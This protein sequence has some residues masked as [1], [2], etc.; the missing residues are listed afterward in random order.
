MWEILYSC[1]N[2][3]G[4]VRR[5]NED[6]FYACGRFRKQEELFNDITVHGSVRSRDRQVFGVYDGMGGE[7]CG[8]MAA[9]LAAEGTE[10]FVGREGDPQAVLRELS[11]VLNRRIFTYAEEASVKVMGSTEV[12]AL[13]AEDGIH[14][15]NIGDS[16]IYRLTKEG[17]EQLS[18]D[19]VLQS[20]RGRKSPLTQHLGIPEKELLLEPHF[21]YRPYKKGDRYLLC[22]DGITDML[23]NEQIY[24]ILSRPMALHDCNEQLVKEAL[25]KGGVDNIT[26][27]VFEI[28][29]RGALLRRTKAFFAFGRSHGSGENRKGS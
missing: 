28:S 21:C 9:Y 24:N 20:F 2:V 15:A 17:I 27:M 12:V 6:N 8:E 4:H 1:S 29:H 7:A 5:N 14:F 16:R 19:H 22:S 18:R 11:A 25:D 23:D 26:S 3:K 13:F 10:D